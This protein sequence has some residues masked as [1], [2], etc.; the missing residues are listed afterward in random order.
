MINTE[1]QSLFKKVVSYTLTTAMLT[2][3]KSTAHVHALIIGKF[4][5]FFLQNA[6]INMTRHRELGI[7]DD[8]SNW[9]S[10]SW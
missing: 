5:P 10:T 6:E 4:L 3:Y 9:T 8:T 7:N 2:L 1:G